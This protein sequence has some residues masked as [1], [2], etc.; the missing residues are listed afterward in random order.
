[1]TVKYTKR[2]TSKAIDKYRKEIKNGSTVDFSS[3]ISMTNP[4]NYELQPGEIG[5][6]ISVSVLHRNLTLLAKKAKAAGITTIGK[7]LFKFFESRHA[8]IFAKVGTFARRKNVK[9][10]GDARKRMQEGRGEVDKFA[11]REFNTSGRAARIACRFMEDDPSLQLHIF[12]ILQSPQADS[13][14]LDIENQLVIKAKKEYGL[15]AINDSKERRTAKRSYYAADPFS[16]FS[17]D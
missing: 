7:K 11:R 1:M 12:P 3:R 8:I 13:N 5:S 4:D 10:G 2:R 15:T 9:K 14:T 16:K 6:Y 17:R